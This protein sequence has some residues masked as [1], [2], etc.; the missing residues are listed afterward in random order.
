MLGL[1]LLG[2]YNGVLLARQI[3]EWQEYEG[4]KPPLYEQILAV[5]L[6][7]SLAILLALKQELPREVAIR[8]SLLGMVEGKPLPLSGERL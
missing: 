4:G 1:P 3:Q 2:I 6:N 5:P 8:I 7:R